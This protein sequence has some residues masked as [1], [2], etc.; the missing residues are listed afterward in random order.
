MNP[1]WP[2]ILFTFFLCLSGGILGAQGLLTVLG[3]GKKMQ[4]VA[5][6]AALVTLVVGG[7][8]VFMHL[9]HWERIFNA[10][11]ALLAGNG[12]GVSGI[13]LELWGCVIE[14]IAIVLFFLFARRA[15]DGVA[16]KWVGVLAII[17]GLA[18]P[19]VTGD[20]YLMPSLPTWDTPLLIVYYLTNT[21]FMGGLAALVIAGVTGDTESRDFMVKTALV[22]AVAQLVVVLVYVFV[23]NGSAGTYSADISFYFDP[24]LPDVPMVDRAAV[25]G[26]LLAGSNALMFW[27]GAII[28]GI[29]VPAVVTWLGKGKD[30]QQLAVYAGGAGVCCIIGGIIWR[31]LLYAAAMHIFALF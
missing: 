28:V 9:Q 3:K 23:I 26:S 12:Y 21:I 22:G 24:T 13:T 11:G 15:E 17:V 14:F 10:F 8:C 18:L 25:V 16:P 20:S 5:L 7:I 6:I 31:V 30:G 19:M 4:N 29:I 1:E 27:L 2:L